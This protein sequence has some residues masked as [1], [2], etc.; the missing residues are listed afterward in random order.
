MP[1]VMLALE[2]WVARHA[3]CNRIGLQPVPRVSAG[4][5]RACMLAERSLSCDGATPYTD[6]PGCFELVR[7]D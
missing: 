6:N 7:H 3:Q 2:A 4:Q 1:P 5:R